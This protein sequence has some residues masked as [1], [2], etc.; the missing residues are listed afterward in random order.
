MAH[1]NELVY[2]CSSF[3]SALLGLYFSGSFAPDRQE[4][5]RIPAW[6]ARFTQMMQPD[7]GANARLGVIAPDCS[8]QSSAAHLGRSS[9]GM[10]SDLGG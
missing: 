3:S 7:A 5:L 2:Y 6:K 4:E 9:G 8:P 1:S 10:T